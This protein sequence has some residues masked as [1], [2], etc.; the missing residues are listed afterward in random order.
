MSG[1]T[2][3][4]ELDGLP[5]GQRVVHRAGD[6]EPDRAEVEQ[7]D[8]A[9]VQPL[10]DLAHTAVQARCRRTSTAPRRAGRPNAARSRSRRRRPGGSSPRGPCRHGVAVTLD[11]RFARRG[12]LGARPHLPGR[13]PDRRR[14]G[15]RR[16]PSSPTVSTVGSNARPASPRGCPRGG[17]GT[18]ARRRSVRGPRPASAGPVSFRDDV[19]QPKAYRRPGSSNVGSVSSRQPPTSISVVGPP[20]WVIS[21]SVIGLGSLAWLSR[22]VRCGRPRRVRSRRSPPS[23][24]AAGSRCG[25]PPN[26]TTS[27]RVFADL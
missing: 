7:R 18:A 5:G 20:M 1:R 15:R 3:R 12:E 16:A 6:R 2:G 21:T 22:A 17:R 9:H 11:R 4:A 24:V 23:R 26:S 8:P 14:A 19:P 25:L 13:G 10:R 27:V